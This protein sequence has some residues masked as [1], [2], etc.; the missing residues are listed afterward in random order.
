VFP[1]AARIEE[2]PSLTDRPFTYVVV[3]STASDRLLIESAAW[4]EADWITI[5]F[6][7]LCMCLS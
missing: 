2:K 5:S 7:L 4:R 1:G 6:R 3:A